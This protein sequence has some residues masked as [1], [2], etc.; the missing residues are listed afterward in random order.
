MVMSFNDSCMPSTQHSDKK[1]V[2]P[3]IYLL[4]E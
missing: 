1:M 2:D 3:D 4:N